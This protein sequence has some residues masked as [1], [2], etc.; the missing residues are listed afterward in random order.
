MN[1]RVSPSD[2]TFLYDGCQRCFYLKVVKKISQPSIP[3]PAVF[4][5]IANLL[6]NHYNGKHTN[7]L[8]SALPPG[9]VILGEKWVR[10]E[11]IQM[12]HYSV[13]CQINGRN[14]L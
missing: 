6:K 13:T 12:P 3:L 4:T 11:I 10:S 8:H 9:K 7:E 5:K 14:Q 2:L 1:Y